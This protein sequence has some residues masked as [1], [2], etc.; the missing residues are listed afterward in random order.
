MYAI[1]VN[2]IFKTLIII[3]KNFRLNIVH[4]YKKK[5]VMR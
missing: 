5:I 2:N 4:N 3:D 1:Q